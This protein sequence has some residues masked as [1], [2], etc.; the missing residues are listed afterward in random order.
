MAMRNSE[1]N[2]ANEL[3]KYLH[4]LTAHLINPPFLMSGRSSVVSSPQWDRTWRDL[5]KSQEINKTS[6]RLNKT[7]KI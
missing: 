3:L 5:E 6:T 7:N 1:T 2:Q 4:P